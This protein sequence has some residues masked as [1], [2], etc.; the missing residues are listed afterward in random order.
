MHVA[1]STLGLKLLEVS[2]GQI[3]SHAT[4][5]QQLAWTTLT[6][7]LELTLIGTSDGTNTNILKIH[8]LSNYMYLHDWP[9]QLSD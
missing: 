1:G 4:I 6:P 7:T 8:S 3:D 2:L 9:L 5:T